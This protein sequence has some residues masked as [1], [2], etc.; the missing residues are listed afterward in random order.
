MIKT[1]AARPVCGDIWRRPPPR[2]LGR[3]TLMSL[4][5][6]DSASSG[7]GIVPWRRSTSG[8]R[9][10]QSSQ[11]AAKQAGIGSTTN[12][13]CPRGAP[14]RQDVL[15][16]DEFDLS[17]PLM[18]IGLDSLAGVEFRNRLQA[19]WR[20][21]R[22]TLVTHA[23]RVRVSVGRRMDRPARVASLAVTI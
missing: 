11:T 14:L 22:P 6:L 18:E 17:T 7:G 4:C 3:Q 8:E 5:C 20:G 10:A 16:T 13:L 1:R 12:P 15:G 2:L 19:L 21:G 9:C 23:N